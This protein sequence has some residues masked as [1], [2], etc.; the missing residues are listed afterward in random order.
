MMCDV[1]V[2][3]PVF[4]RKTVVIDALESILRQTLLPHQIIIVDDGS[5]DGSFEAIS[6]W[7]DQRGLPRFDHQ[8][9]RIQLFKQNKQTAAA[10]RKLGMESCQAT[11]FI[12]FLDSDDLWPTDF[13]ERTVAV[14]SEDANTVASFADRQYINASGEQFHH[15]NC[16]ML[17]KDPVE[18]MFRHGA[19]IASC[20]LFRWDAIVA[21]AGWDTNLNTGEDAVLFLSVA[22]M[23]TWRHCSGSAVCFRHGNAAKIDEEGNLSFKHRDTFRRWANCYEHIYASLAGRYAEPQRKRLRNHLA[24]YWYR[25]GKQLVLAGSREEAIACFDMAISWKPFRLRPRYH[26]YTA[27]YKIDKTAA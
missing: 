3:I 25:A 15:D 7:I 13:L 11:K 8:E 16:Q 1:T 20:S 17:A 18:W 9:Q 27:R 19:G 6:E 26:R 5:T 2:I 10:A 4:N 22:T 23:G 14:M 21:A 12:A 24:N